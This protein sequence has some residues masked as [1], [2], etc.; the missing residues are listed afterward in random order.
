M[1]GM[2]F[3]PS[4]I[5]HLYNQG[6][7]K[8]M[9]FSSP[10]DYYS[11]LIKMRKHVLPVCELLAYSLMP[12]H[13]HLVIQ[14]TLKSCEPVRLGYLTSNRLSNAIR[15]LLSQ[16][17]QDFNKANNRSG[18][19]FRQKTK[20]KC[21]SELKNKD[22]ALLC[23]NY[24]H[25]N[26]STAGLVPKSADWPYCS[27]RDYLGVRNGTLCNKNLAFDL[28]GIDEIYVREMSGYY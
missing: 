21:L 3:L 28:L 22:A 4:K 9:I 15:L 8:E 26:A 7:N 17:C 16:Y 18:S 23:V 12:N 5:Y 20:G 10:T 11:F 14:T 19:L 13:F 27:L 6:N 2:K 24:I 1:L 25:N